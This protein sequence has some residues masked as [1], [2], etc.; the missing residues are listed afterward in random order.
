[1]PVI[2]S[3]RFPG[4]EHR[5]LS[6]L[7]QQPGIQIFILLSLC[8]FLFVFGVGRWDLW[9]PDEPRYAQVAKEM[10]ERGDSVSLNMMILKD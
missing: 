9:N 8:F 10:V 2:R 4:R 5:K 1:M 3:E 6:R 7:F